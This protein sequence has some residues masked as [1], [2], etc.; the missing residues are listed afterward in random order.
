MNVNPLYFA[1][2]SPTES[3]KFY[4]SRRRYKRLLYTFMAY[5]TVEMVK[6]HWH[7]VWLNTDP[8]LVR[9]IAYLIYYP[10]YHLYYGFGN[11]EIIL[12]F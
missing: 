3:L 12:K 2:L 6:F 11:V 4:K 10:I 1:A 9:D 5:M 8:T 7:Q